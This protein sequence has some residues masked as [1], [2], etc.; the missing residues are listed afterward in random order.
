VPD[1]LRAK[2]VETRPVTAPTSPTRPRSVPAG[3]AAIPDAGGWLSAPRATARFIRDPIALLRSLAARHGPTFRL[4]LLDGPSVVT[5]DPD[6]I[7]EMYASDPGLLDAPNDIAAPLV[8]RR[9]VVVANGALHKHKRKMLAPPFH[10]ARMRAYGHTIADATLRALDG[11]AVGDPVDVLAITQRLSLEVILRA[12]FGVSDAARVAAL[13]AAITRT[14]AGLPTWLLF[15]RP[16]HHT[17]GGAGPWARYQAAVAALERLLRD[18]I[19]RAR[20]A[21]AESRDDVLALLLSARDEADQPMPDDELVDE[22]RTLVIAGH[23]TTATTLA[24]TLWELHRNPPALAPLVEALGALGDAPSPEAL[25]RAP[26]LAATCD[27]AMRM[28]PIVPIFR[29]RVTRDARIAGHDL[30]AGTLL[31]PA[32]ALTHYDPAIFAEPDAFRPARFLE[33]RYAASEFMPFGGGDRRCLGA[34]FANYELQV[35]LGTWLT[36]HRFEAEPGAPLRLVM[37]GITARPSDRVL[38]RYRGRA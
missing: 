22:L 4:A 18:E 14:V 35:A 20:A 36:R 26:L 11:L 34:A 23:E 19:A 29:R 30:R 25:A 17:F 37:N 8:G 9:S 3:A 32:V 15:A 21:P 6:F 16:L 31:S 28:H 2:V 24:W 13:R 7:R 38:L 27:E 33:R 10:G 5:G 1:P 12:V